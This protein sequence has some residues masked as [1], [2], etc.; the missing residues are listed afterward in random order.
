MCPWIN[1]LS[2][3]VARLP[4]PC[5]VWPAPVLQEPLH[6]ESCLWWRMSS[7][8]DAPCPHWMFADP[9]SAGPPETAAAWRWSL[10]Y[11][12]IGQNLLKYNIIYK[13]SIKNVQCTIQ[14]I[15][16]KNHES[17]FYRYYLYTQESTSR[18]NCAESDHLCQIITGLTYQTNKLT[19]WVANGWSTAWL[20]DLFELTG[21]TLSSRGMPLLC[22]AWN[23]SWLNSVAILS[24]IWPANN[25][26]YIER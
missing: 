10:R 9:Q 26:L 19:D 17:I 23:C 2:K 11:A 3:C 6:L 22:T 21:L 7:G 14:H 25:G 12:G 18:K 5:M 1:C 20:I 4:D 13:T 24:R 15:D 16:K 8:S